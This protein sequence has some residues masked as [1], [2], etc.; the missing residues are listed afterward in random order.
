MRTKVV[1]SEIVDKSHWTERQT[2]SILEGQTLNRI[3]KSDPD[4]PSRTITND[5]ERVTWPSRD[6]DVVTYV[7]ALAAVDQLYLQ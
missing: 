4:Q 3:I 2:V 7:G 5:R 1:R 6:R